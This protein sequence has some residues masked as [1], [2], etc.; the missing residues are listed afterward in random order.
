MSLTEEILSQQS[1]NVLKR[2]RGA[3]RFWSALRSGEI[4]A[5]QV[6]TNS[7]ETIGECDID[8]AICGGTLGI[9]LGAALQQLGWRVSLIERGILKGRKQEW[10]IS[11]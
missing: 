7:S 5:P 11:T 4:K 2:L 1:D 3:D 10:N 9:L 8:I 6:V